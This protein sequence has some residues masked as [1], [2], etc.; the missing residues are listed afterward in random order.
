MK[1]ISISCTESR[2]L[3]TFHG[4]EQSFSIPN[5]TWFINA[6]YSKH[7][8]DY[9]WLERWRKI[10]RLFLFQAYCVVWMAI[11]EIEMSGY[12]Q[13]SLSKAPTQTQRMDTFIDCRIV[14]A[15]V[16]LFLNAFMHWFRTQSWIE[17]NIPNCFSD[18]RN[19]RINTWTMSI[20]HAWNGVQ[21]RVPIFHNVY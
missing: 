17:V 6:T 11:W 5:T 12:T 21:K 1:C 13:V 8:W 19:M 18:D 16:V 20:K 3:R 10:S 7:Q 14:A 2:Q 15:L 9:F 4:R